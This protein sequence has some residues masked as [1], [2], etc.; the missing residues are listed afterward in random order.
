MR[1]LPA[2]FAAVVT[3]ATLSCGVAAADELPK[4]SMTGH[5]SLETVDGKTMTDAD[6]RGKWMLVYFGYTYCP[7]VCPT[8]LNE[9][10]LALNELGPLASKVQPIF[11]TI[12]PVRDK[13]PVLKKYLESFDPRILG[14]RGDGD[15]TEAAAKSFHVY[16]R[17]RT[18][19]NG[20]YSYDHSGY[21]YLID[22]KGKFVE[23]LTA[24]LPG[25]KLA[26]ELRKEIKG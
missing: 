5:F 25:H 15:E 17:A 4:P 7:D 23:L 24:D 26:A 12:D 22:D 11:I 9:I 18:L 21:V 16:Y 10:V 20:E 19:G 6:F 14:L 3:A 2:A 8:V 13:P 1:L